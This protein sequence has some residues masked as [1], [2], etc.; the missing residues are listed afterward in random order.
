MH[1][2][3]C[4]PCRRPLSQELCFSILYGIIFVSW[5]CLG[6]AFVTFLRTYL[7]GGWATCGGPWVLQGG[8]WELQALFFSIFGGHVGGLGGPFF[9]Q[10][11]SL[12]FC[13]L[14]GPGPGP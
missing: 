1:I 9:N 8:P 12:D 4:R 2:N 5:G 14:G 6:K 13:F 3:I 10:S 11:R 7:G